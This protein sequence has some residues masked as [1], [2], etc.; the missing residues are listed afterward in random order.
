MVKVA[1]F[2]GSSLATAECVKR[3]ADIVLGDS[4]RR[5][6]VLSAP[7]KASPQDT[8]VTDLLIAAVED[9]Q[10]GG[11][12]SEA[13]E[14]VR[15]RFYAIGR[16][17]GLPQQ[18][19]RKELGILAQ[20][21]GEARADKKAFRDAVVS[22]G[23]HIMARLF[24]LYLGKVRKVN[25]G[26]VDPKEA[27]LLV[28]DTYGDAYPLPDT[29]ERLA[30]KLSGRDGIVVLPGFY[31]ITKGGKRA[32]FSRGGSDLTGALVAE[33]V[34]AD[35]YENWTD[36]DGI[37]RADP[38]IIP[39]AEVIPEITFRE[40]REL[41]YLG[42]RVLHHD[43]IIPVRRKRIPVNLRNVNNLEH[44]GT[45]IV[46]SRI[47]L[48]E[49]VVGV[50]MKKDFCCFTI[51]KY[52]MNREI[53]FGRR[54]LSIF[55]EA[56]L[57]YE[58]MPSGID[59]ISVYLDQTQLRKDTAAEIIR[60]LYKELDAERVDVEHDKAMVIAVGEGMKR[61]VGVAAR[62]VGALAKKKINIEM[63]NQGA[64]ELSVIFGVRA[65]DGEAAVKAIYDEYFGKRRRKPKP[66]KEEAEE[67]ER[68]NLA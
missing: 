39:H 15:K 10:K 6:V 58:H 34:D 2:G 55:E 27:G 22:L 60:R 36:V 17:L 41:A 13:F 38:R 68:G 11:S 48:A 66:Q 44:P 47:P 61:H 43:A 9:I 33:A 24:A 40:I 14:E 31:G 35:V 49:I 7:G 67:P 5:F 53:G 12:G 64:S 4:D 18:A 29:P 20:T 3:A 19:V 52:L 42:F 50:A 57:S 65:E 37:C 1:K 28:T 45:M 54:V 46:E 63:I 51:E 25:A 26:F 59:S 56:G 23:E 62:L 32:T 21:A 30:R 8:K 16:G